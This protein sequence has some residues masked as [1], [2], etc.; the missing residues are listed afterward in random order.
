[1]KVSRREFVKGGAAAFT[2]GFAAPAFLTDLARAQQATGRSLV[3]LYLGGGNDALSFLV[4]YT[5]GAYY[6]RRPTQAVPAE[7]VLQIGTDAGGS[8]LGLHPNLASR[9]STTATWR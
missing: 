8:A 9:C 7:R 6:A 5:D 1:M 2:M 4:P 3:V